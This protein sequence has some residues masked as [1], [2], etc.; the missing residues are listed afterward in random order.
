MNLHHLAPLALSV[1]ILS[2]PSPSHAAVRPWLSGAIGGSTYAM[3]DVN[4]DIGALNSA[5]AGSGLSMD[6]ITRGL[7]AGLAFGLDV[8]NGLSLGVGFDRLAGSSDVGD[9]S[10]SIEYDMPAN[11]VRAFGRYAFESGSK[12]QGFLEAS[13]GRVM[14]AGSATVSVTGVG[15][16]SGDL[17]GSGLALEGG[18]GV[19]LWVAPQLALT[20]AAGFRH[21]V[22]GSTEFDGRPIY[23]ASGGDYQLDYSGLF[24]RVGL[25]VSLAP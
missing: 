1:V 15:S 25:Q 11:L 17:S 13:L 21:A 12:A 20:G 23:N 2:A 24:A 18:G 16:E 8:G 7:N 19:L 9:W 4:D 14:A 22:V 5:I 3:G 10:A 6:E